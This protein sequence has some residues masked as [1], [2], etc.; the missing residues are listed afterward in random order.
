MLYKIFQSNVVPFDLEV[1]IKNRILDEG[2]TLASAVWAIS[3]CFF[4]GIV[5]QNRGIEVIYLG[6]GAVL[7]TF[8]NS[9]IKRRIG[10]E[11]GKNFIFIDQTDYILGASFFYILI[12]D[13]DLRIFIVGLI[14]SLILH[15]LVNLL[16]SFYEKKIL[17]QKK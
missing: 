12:K 5:L 13:L 15:P 7:G 17:K 14:I 11:R 4:I 9:F 16:R 8:L 1:K 2:R 3:V 6:V 10:L